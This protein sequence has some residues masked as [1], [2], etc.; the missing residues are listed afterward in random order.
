ML[1][2]LISAGVGLGA[3]F[4]QFLAQRREKRSEVR[5]TRFEEAQAKAIYNC[6]EQLSLLVRGCSQALDHMDDVAF[7]EKGYAA[8]ADFRHVSRV[9]RM[10]MPSLRK[11]LED[12]G[13]TAFAVLVRIRLRQEEGPPT[14]P[15]SGGDNRLF[16]ALAALEKL[17]DELTDD[18]GA[19][20]RELMIGDSKVES[21]LEPRRALPPAKQ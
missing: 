13:D 2:G 14:S 18:L 5:R 4:V 17:A 8:L 12:A 11:R 6:N 19:M 16:E 1:S 20:F 21:L 7:R 9:S 3:W 10:Y 15:T